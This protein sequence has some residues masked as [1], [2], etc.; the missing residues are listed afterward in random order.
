MSKPNQ[1]GIVVET[2]PVKGLAQGPRHAGA[3]PS[4][5]EAMGKAEV[6]LARDRTISAVIAFAIAS[7]A[8]APRR[9]SRSD[10]EKS[11]HAGWTPLER[12]L[13]RAK[14]AASGRS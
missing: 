5:T 1:Y 11:G 14:L 3:A 8:D 10:W 13:N 9:L 12:E 4:L 2:L 6:M 7:P